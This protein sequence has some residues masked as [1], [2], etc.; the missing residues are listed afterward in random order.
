MNGISPGRR[1]WRRSRIDLYRQH[2]EA[3]IDTRVPALGNR[4]PRQV[5]GTPRGRERLEA[6]LAGIARHE[7]TDR[8]A[9]AEAMAELRRQLGLD[10]PEP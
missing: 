1:N 10:E 3:W 2:L 4:T 9:R 8:P 5:S 7:R 6:L